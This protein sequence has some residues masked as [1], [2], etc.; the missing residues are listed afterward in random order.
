MHIGIIGLGLIGGSIAKA[1]KNV[2]VQNSYITAYDLNSADLKTAYEEGIIDNIAQNC[3]SDFTSCSVIFICTPVSKTAEIVTG[4]L[5]HVR[6]DCI[7]TDVGSTKY[8]IASK[9]T[10]LIE[11]SQ[12]RVY[13]VGGHPMTGSERFGYSASSPQLFENAYYMLTPMGDT[14]DFI[15]FILQKLI[16]RMGALPLVLSATYHD[17]ATANISHLPHIVASSLVHLIRDNDGTNRHL[18]ALAAG[19]FKDLTRIASS[20]PNIWTGICLSNKDQIMRVFES[21]RHILDHFLEILENND[22]DGLYTYF[23]T[24]RIY[25][26]TFK[27]GA[28]SEI[29][30]TYAL[31]VDAKDEPGA[32]AAIASLLSA[33]QINIKNIGI[34]S[35]RE[36]DS[37]VLKIVVGSKSDLLQ[38]T[39]ILSKHR[40]NIYY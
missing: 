12:K 10:Q 7:L 31:H 40:Y 33:H 37:G 30:K 1:F 6:N 11:E 14:P 13:F 22:E 21:Y 23:D 24:A 26:N 18:H 3:T 35:D 39:E 34:I 28:T 17:Y 29:A 8:E 32:I 27:E 4:L 5:P 16:E 9:I 36:F 2:H 38:A 19:G 25:R 15:L 20:N